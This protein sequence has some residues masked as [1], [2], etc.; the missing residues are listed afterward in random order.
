[1]MPAQGEW[2][3]RCVASTAVVTG[4]NSKHPLTSNTITQHW[5]RRFPW[6]SALQRPRILTLTAAGQGK[7]QGKCGC[8][9]TKRLISIPEEALLFPP[10]SWSI[11]NG[12]LA[13]SVS[14]VPRLF[15]SQRSTDG[16][17][18]L[19]SGKTQSAHK[20]TTS[21]FHPFSFRPPYFITPSPSLRHRRH[22]R[23]R[24]LVPY[25]YPNQTTPMRT[26][27]SQTI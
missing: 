1:M 19:R 25:Q 13:W 2:G 8:R 3:A 4:Q 21:L 16:G 23:P 17:E 20:E 12:R 5:R 27:S 14:N 11:A 24:T 18:Q 10:P 26:R 6:N 9:S 15:L 22:R 7:I